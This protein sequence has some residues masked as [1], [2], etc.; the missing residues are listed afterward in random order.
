MYNGN[1][2]Q[3]PLC[4]ASCAA[5]DIPISPRFSP[6]FSL[7]P[8]NFSTLQC[9]ARSVQQYILHRSRTRSGQ[10]YILHRCRNGIEKPPN[11]NEDTAGH[12]DT[13]DTLWASGDDQTRT[14]TL[15]FVSS[16]RVI[17]CACEQQQGTVPS[18]F[19]VCNVDYIVDI[20]SSDRIAREHC[21]FLEHR[22]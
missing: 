7:S 10:Q 22:F 1:V 11:S 16:V 13:C 6:T 21:R 15:I 14:F 5:K 18:M 9:T 3:N 17:S 4:A 12:R 2:Q 19:A 8:G 20:S